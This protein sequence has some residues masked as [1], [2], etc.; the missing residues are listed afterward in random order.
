[1]NR[2]HKCRSCSQ[3]IITPGLCFI[4]EKRDKAQILSIKEGLERYKNNKCYV[5][6]KLADTRPYGD[7]GQNICHP[8]MISDPK[9]QETAYRIVAERMSG[10]GPYILTPEGPIAVQDLADRRKSPIN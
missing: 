3:D 4:C 9:R 5:C 6:Q 1:M 7:D 8:C 10:P 2:L